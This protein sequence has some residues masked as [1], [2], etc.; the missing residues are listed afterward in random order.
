MH[1]LVQRSASGGG[2]RGSGDGGAGG[3]G[4]GDG[5][6]GDGGSGSG[7]G[8]NVG[9]GGGRVSEGNLTPQSMQSVPNLHGV[10]Q[11]AMRVYPSGVQINIGMVWHR[12][13]YVGAVVEGECPSRQR[14]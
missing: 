2:L 5:G 8:A 11:L 13:L 7:D 4:D 9:A 6:S 1:V 14:M 10:E 3:R 12:Q